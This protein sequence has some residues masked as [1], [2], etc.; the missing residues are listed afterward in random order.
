MSNKPMSPSAPINPPMPI[1]APPSTYR[2]LMLSVVFHRQ[3]IIFSP[4]QGACCK[5]SDCGPPAPWTCNAN[6]LSVMDLSIL[7]RCRIRVKPTIIRAVV[8]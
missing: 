7:M 6:G 4:S 3:V 8:L 2:R 1:P 5:C